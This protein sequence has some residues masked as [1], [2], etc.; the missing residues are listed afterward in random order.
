MMLAIST[1]CVSSITD[2]NWFR[3]RSGKLSDREVL[4]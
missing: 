4:N 3:A 1:R 2:D